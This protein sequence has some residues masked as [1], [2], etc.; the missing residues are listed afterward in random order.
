[1]SDKSNDKL[2]TAK[3]LINLVSESE[4]YTSMELIETYIE[5]GVGLSSLPIQ[6]LYL[7]IKSLPL[8]KITNC[9]PMFSK[10]QR[11]AFLDL[12]LWV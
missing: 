8:E 12:D 3:A 11:K 7:A 6:P 4:A 9:L 10:E 5:K 2:N 1:M